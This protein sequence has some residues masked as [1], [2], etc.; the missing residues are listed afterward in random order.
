MDVYRIENL[1][2]NRLPVLETLRLHKDGWRVCKVSVQGVVGRVEGR[3][4][5]RMERQLVV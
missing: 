1:R 3:K 2:V 5:G 4:S